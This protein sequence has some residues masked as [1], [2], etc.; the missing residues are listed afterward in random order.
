MALIVQGNDLASA[1]PVVV[2]VVVGRVDP[3]ASRIHSGQMALVH[4]D[5]LLQCLLG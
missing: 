1:S 2:R 5:I 4:I 3:E